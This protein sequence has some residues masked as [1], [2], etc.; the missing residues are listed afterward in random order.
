M[1]LNYDWK[2]LEAININGNFDLSIEM[3]NQIYNVIT[4]NGNEF[5]LDYNFLD[6]D[7][8]EGLVQD[9]NCGNVNMETIN[10]RVENLFDISLKKFKLEVLEFIA[11]EFYHLK[12]NEVDINRL[13][14]L[15]DDAK[16]YNKKIDL[17]G[18][19]ID[20]AL[21]MKKID[22]LEFYDNNVFDKEKYDQDLRIKEVHFN[23]HYYSN[24]DTGSLE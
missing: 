13:E 5:E 24:K 19:R 8:F 11:N 7:R 2:E 6:Y 22:K 20:W 4:N 12:I 23:N 3:N 21:F 15:I 1:E 16:Y 9:M 18:D 14:A 17:F 10:R